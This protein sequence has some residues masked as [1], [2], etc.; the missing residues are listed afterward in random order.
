[1]AQSS[2]AVL[3]SPCPLLRSKRTFKSTLLAEATL[4]GLRVYEYT[5]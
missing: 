3:P 2:R 1:M 5:P 4:D